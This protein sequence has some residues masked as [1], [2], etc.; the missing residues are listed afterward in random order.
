MALRDILHTLRMATVSGHDMLLDHPGP[1][2]T[3]PLTLS[4]SR[5]RIPRFSAIRTRSASNL[6]AHFS[7][8]LAPMDL[9][10]LLGYTDLA[11]DLL[12]HKAARHQCHNLALAVA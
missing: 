5:P 8:E 2:A 11:R 9:R 3:H 6:A 4:V 1:S 12:V 10:C 7:H